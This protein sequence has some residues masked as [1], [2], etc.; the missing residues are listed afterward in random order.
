M[1]FTM[2]FGIS[3][4]TINAAAQ[5]EGSVSASAPSTEKEENKI[6]VSLGDSM[7][8]GY[9]LEGYEPNGENYFGFLV[10]SA[11]EAY[12]EEVAKYFGWDLIQLAT[13][14]LRAD[15]VYYLLNYGTEY[16]VEWDEYG[17]QYMYSKF[18]NRYMQVTGDTTPTY[19]EV[20]EYAAK[21]FQKAVYEDAD[22]ISVAVGSNNFATLLH[23]R[24]SY[25][26]ARITGNYAMF[27]GYSGEFDFDDLVT[28]LDKE[29]PTLKSD[30]AKLY[31]EIEKM[32]LES[33]A[34]AGISL[35]TV[36]GVDGSTMGD[37]V[38]D[39]T[40]A[41]VYTSAGFAL[42]YKGIMDTIQREN[43]EAEVIIVGL[44]NWFQDVKFSLPIGEEGFVVDMGALIDKA[45]GI[46]DSYTAVLPA[47]Y[48]GEQTVY[49]ADVNG[50][51][52]DKIELIIS[53]IAEN[54]NVDLDALYAIEDE[55][56]RFAKALEYAKSINSD[57]IPAGTTR[58]RL[59]ERLGGMVI[60][61]M[62]LTVPDLDDLDMYEKYLAGTFTYTTGNTHTIKVNSGLLGGSQIHE[63][64][65]NAYLD[66]ANLYLED[67]YNAVVDA[68]TIEDYLD[69]AQKA[70]IA[71]GDPAKIGAVL[72]AVLPG[73]IGK[74]IYDGVY[75]YQGGCIAYL[76]LEKSMIASTN[77]EVLNAADL[78]LISDMNELMTYVFDR[79]AGHMGSPDEI[80][81]AMIADSKLMT[82]D[83]I[84]FSFMIGD[85]VILH[86]SVD[87]HQTIADV[88]IDA[89][90]NEYTA[91]QKALEDAIYYITEYYDEAYAY[92]YQYALDNGYIAEA[93]EA[94]DDAIEAVN[95]IDVTDTEITDAFKAK[96]NAELE[97]IVATLEE[98]REVLAYN[99]AADVDGLV[100]AILALED[101]LYTHLEN[102]YAILAQAGVDVNNLVII[103]A[104]EDL[105][106]YINEVVIPAAIDAAIKL[107]DAVYARLVEL[108]T[109]AYYDL[110][111]AVKYYSHEAAK[112]AYYWLYNNPETVIEFF[113]TY[114]DEIVDLFSEYGI[115]AL[116][117]IGYVGSEFGDEIATFLLDNADVIIPAFVEWYSIHGDLVWDLIKVYVVA[118]VEYYE[119]DELVAGLVNDFVEQ[120]TKE[121]TTLFGYLDALVKEYS[122]ELVAK[123][124]A[125][126]EELKNAAI[127]GAE[128][129]GAFLLD[130]VNKIVDK[131]V[132]AEYTPTDDSYYVAVNGGN[133]AYAYLVAEALGL[134]EEQVGLT[135]WGDI[136][137]E[138]LA[139]ADFITVGFDENELS[140]FAI[141]QM[142]AYV[143]A[144]VDGTLRGSVND[145]ASNVFA[146]LEDYPIV[147]NRQEETVAYIN[148][149][150]DELVSIEL[151][152]D[153]ELAPM[154]WAA[155]VGED[156]VQYVEAI[157]ANIRA[158]LVAAGII[159]T[160]TQSIDVID[161]IYTEYPEIET[162]VIKQAK[163]YDE[164]GDSAYYTIEIPVVDSIMFAIEAYLYS[165]VAFNVEYQ[166]LVV[167][168][169]K[170]NPEATVVLLS[171]YNAFD[172]V[173]FE[174]GDVAVDL[175]DAYAYVA[176][177][178]SVQPFAYALLG[179]NVGYADINGVE[180][181]Y[182]AMGAE[183]DVA[184]F[185]LAYLADSSITDVSEAGNAY[186]CD[187]IMS[188]LTVGCD[189]KY[190][191]ACDAFCNKCGMER[192]VGDHIYDDE[193]D[194]TC[195]EC[196]HVREIEGVDEECDHVYEWKVAEAATTTST[197][198]EIGRCSICGE[199]TSRIIP[200]LPTPPTPG[201]AHEYDN[202]C[203]VDCNKC[204][205]EREVGDHVYGDDNIC[206]ECGHEKLP[207]PPAPG[208]DHEYDNACDVDCNKCGE[209]REV[210]DHVYGDDNICDECGHEK[211]DP[212]PGD[213]D[214]DE[215]KDDDE[216]KGD[217]EEE[218]NGLSGGAIAGITIGSVA[219]AGVG[220]F[221]VYWFAVKKSTFAA[222][223]VATKALFSKEKFAAAGAAIKGL[224]KKEKFAAAGKAIKDFFTKLFG[225]K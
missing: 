216:N 121:F 45:Y 192:V 26:L 176:A 41:V 52:V 108:A 157:L 119:V 95:A 182:E 180:T 83:N 140:A 211:T 80:A 13:S 6:Y 146:K 12:P 154:D 145:Y 65:I 115:Y 199:F 165:Y 20:I 47:I 113:V 59:L 123:I 111:G 43:S 141:D 88:I 116:A 44:T 122:E 91:Q 173:T 204:G 54:S 184:T 110:I 68:I 42:G 34:E 158:E 134:T 1:V 172:G 82:V 86:P 69:D 210:G 185:I 132:R 130:A 96:F 104:L 32:L 206:D 208:C 203:D 100:D 21:T 25:W 31:V 94:I 62:S 89:Y 153:K 161:F 215:N 219:A 37:L 225:G 3:A 142:L 38:K 105:E 168:I 217:D 24:T 175:G 85:G 205:E 120:V 53:A 174:L 124:Y 188:I 166:N 179:L 136:N 67:K 60:S 81:A 92:G 107:A 49:Y 207:T 5:S 93:I 224:F 214:E 144:Y 8:N 22:V 76:G 148:S 197:G 56:E 190:D 201:C 51:G 200:K 117:A 102:A 97:A 170:I 16:E 171:G 77:V 195:N 48:G 9:G 187:Q 202:A 84:I 75:G 10:D 191:N 11:E 178:A 74:L 46:A 138:A 160:Y 23:M 70:E 149:I 112:A 186:I 29:I 40:N 61:S 17:T 137:Y 18:E 27:G 63:V 78:S 147:T 15:D 7:T 155:L 167:D 30:I 169:C 103:P 143:K 222:L 135:T 209:E 58:I 125:L 14:G 218:K 98:L 19:D 4:T 213:E 118:L 87:G 2:L 39:M 131:A 189:H 57:M 139:K 220:G 159:E 90:E 133:A 33:A 71:T 164:L 101:D 193:F 55:D 114:G 212:T 163:L 28:D 150:I 151:I 162:E 128:E 72:G 129:L 106:I 127:D 99:E 194:A 181:V 64:E 35:D 223:A 221:A 79:L 66:A 198:I 36:I 156:K 152:A 73:L 109:D 126:I 177:L 196:G 50:E 183:Y